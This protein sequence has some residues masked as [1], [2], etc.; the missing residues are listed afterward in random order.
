MWIGVQIAAI[1]FL[2]ALVAAAV[3]VFVMSIQSYRL[4]KQLSHR[5]KALEERHTSPD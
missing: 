5:V 4:L 2:V 1:V 3:I